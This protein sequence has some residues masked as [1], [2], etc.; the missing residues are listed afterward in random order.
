[1]PTSSS[2]SRR[3]N[4]RRSD[5]QAYDA[6]WHPAVPQQRIDLG[7]L[8]ADAGGLEKSAF[9]LI[10]DAYL[11]DPVDPSSWTTPMME[12]RAFMAKYYPDGDI[13]DNFNV[14]GRG[15]ELLAM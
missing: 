12:W 2:T 6:D 4:S 14:Y 8:G 7:R 9:G 10:T 13:K 5:P 15:A 3:P 11:K 1:V